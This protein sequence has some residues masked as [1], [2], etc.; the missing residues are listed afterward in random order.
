MHSVMSHTILILVKFLATLNSDACC[1]ARTS[2]HLDVSSALT[3]LKLIYGILFQCRTIHVVGCDT[4]TTHL[5][6]SRSGLCN[7]GLVFRQV[8]QCHYTHA[9]DPIYAD[10]AIRPETSEAW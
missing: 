3:K 10:P 5:D 2:S 9:F 6:C 8:K 1:V 4:Q 7:K